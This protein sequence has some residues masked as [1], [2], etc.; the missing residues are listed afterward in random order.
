[1]ARTELKEANEIVARLHRHH[2]PV[3]GHR[4]SIGA[5]KGGRIVGCAIVGRPVARQS[6]QKF[7]AEVTRCTTDGT[8][9]ACSFLYG[10]AARVA[11]LLGYKLIQTFV[12]QTESG[13][14]LKAAG[15]E[16]LGITKA[17][18][19]HTRGGRRH[20]QPEEP[21]VKWIKRLNP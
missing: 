4:F 9:N 13:T 7:I 20:D 10:R 17:G 1:M 14:S 6:D 21:K 16:C 12:L 18:S 5:E 15:W 11:E 3:A 2:K 19:W 8:R